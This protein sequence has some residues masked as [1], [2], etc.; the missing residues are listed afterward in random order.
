MVV[1]FMRQPVNRSVL[2]AVMT[3]LVAVLA[4]GVN[5]IWYAN[6]VAQQS[7]HNWCD[8]ITAMD[9]AYRQTPPASPLGRKLAADMHNLRQR[10]GCS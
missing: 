4:V 1:R 3:L 2:Y 9:D 5:S 6:R 8:L 7:N 10:L